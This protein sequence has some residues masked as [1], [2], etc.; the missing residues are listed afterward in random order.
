MKATLL[1]KNIG[2]LREGTYVFE[3]DK[4]NII[5]SAN[6]AGK[7]S[8][9][10]ALTAILS[11]PSD[12][13]LSGVEALEEARKLGIKT[14]PRNPYEGFVNVHA[15]QGSVELE[16]N[17]KDE[18]YIVKQ[19]GD[20]L[21]A[22]EYGDQRFL[23][24]GVLSNNSRVLRQLRGLDKKEPDDFKWAVDELSN[25]QRY[26][27][28]AELLQTRKEDL[29]EKRALVDKSLKQLEPLKQRQAVLEN[30][31]KIL[32]S[33]LDAL[34]DRFRESGKSAIDRDESL[35][36]INR[37]KETIQ[38]KKL[39]RTKIDRE[40]LTPLLKKLKEV[41]TLKTQT[42]S[43]LK[44]AEQEIA[45][46]KGK[47]ARKQE[48]EKE[49]NKLMDDRN[50]LDGRLNLYVV[51][52]TSFRRRKEERVECPLCMHGYISYAGLVQNISKYRK[53]RAD[54]NEKILQLNQEKQNISVRLSKNEEKAKELRSRL[55]EKIEEIGFIKKELKT[56]QDAIRLIDD[57]IAEK[58]ELLEKEKQT[59]E[60]LSR[61]ISKADDDVNKEY[62]EKSK[63]R[64]ELHEQLGGVRQVI[65]ELSSIDVYG[66]M[67]APEAARKVCEDIVS[68][69]SDRTDYLE[70]RAEEEREEAAER[71]NK[72]ISVLM[73]SLGFSE[74]RTI[75]LVGSPSYR[76]YVERFDPEKKEYK[77]QD[78]GTLSTSEK[79]A[80]A[81]I[82]QIA[83]KETY[84]KK[85]P[86]FILDDVLEGFDSERCEKVINYLREKVKLEDWFIIATRLVEE[87][88]V[89]RVKHL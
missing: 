79:L 89:P 11:I 71:F 41:E 77:S 24:A 25:A 31:L 76:L 46:L 88:D 21:V 4:L 10:K 58:T 6:S 13:A 68:I 23:L 66:M 1:I 38:S 62:N 75:K 60:D 69:L 5:E 30:E 42:E 73:T 53:T 44:K 67:L 87:L 12:G 80:T 37:L 3:S 55:R 8:I 33:K 82:L 49:I 15:N 51:A 78:V 54:L 43:E 64:S 84:M 57:F 7:T 59:Y 16:F 22:P 63:R 86:F 20:T 19:N 65:S 9:V 17:G 34:K 28:I 39:E 36:N 61:K 14:D 29:A 40:H 26:S 18:K 32:D 2:G 48:I 72:N 47:D 83:L 56:P 74:F 81:L 35:K 52:E 85:L 45:T 27:A 70:A 50:V